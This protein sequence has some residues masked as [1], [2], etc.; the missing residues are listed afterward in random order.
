MKYALLIY[1]GGGYADLTEAEGKELYTRHG[2]FGATYGDRLG[3]G[4][5]LR[6]P[7][8][9]TSVR[10]RPEG[11]VVTDGPFAETTEVLGGFYLVEADDLDQA[12]E[13]ARDVPALPGDVIEVRPLRGSGDRPA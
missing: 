2:A 1:G 5:E 13:I 10:H 11:I 4:A 3:G 8:T 6:D 12:V 7:D 9:A